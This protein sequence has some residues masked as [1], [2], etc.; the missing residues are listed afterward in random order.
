[1]ETKIKNQITARQLQYLL[2]VGQAIL[3]CWTLQ[4]NL[5]PEN[6]PIQPNSGACQ[7]TRYNEGI[8]PSTVG[9]EDMDK[10]KGSL[11]AKAC[12]SCPVMALAIARIPEPNSDTSY[13]LII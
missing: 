4:Q 12:L 9:D 7:T 5:R 10:P 1:M 8:Q 2:V 13:I 3:R 11:L 6:G